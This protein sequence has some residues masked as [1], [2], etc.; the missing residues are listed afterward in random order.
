M[1]SL[2]DT[3]TRNALIQRLQQLAPDTRAKWGHFDAP[4]MLCHLNDALALSLGEIPSRP[5]N[6]RAFQHFPLKHL[7]LYVFPFPRG[8]AAPPD[9]LTS[10]PGGFDVDREQVVQRM[11][12][13]SESAQTAGAEHP[14]FGPLSNDEW[15]SLHWKHID[16][17][18]K[19]FGC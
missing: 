4:R 7:V 19:Q 13:I 16:H 3:A 5:M 12:R 1:P 18:L 15:N 10:Q 17:H 11:E 14:L 8:A 2:R 6:K 9:T